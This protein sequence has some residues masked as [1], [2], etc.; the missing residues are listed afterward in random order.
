MF[1]CTYV[2]KD[3]SP[4]KLDDPLIGKFLGAFIKTLEIKKVVIIAPSAS[5]LYALPYLFNDPSAVAD[6]VVG[7]VP[8]APVGTGDFKTKYADSKV[9][10]SQRSSLLTCHILVCYTSFTLCIKI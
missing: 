1:K 10:L 9:S 7:F 6:Q 5:G 3:K 8:I 4:D 2:G